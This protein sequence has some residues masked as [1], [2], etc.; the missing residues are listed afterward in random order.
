VKSGTV[1]RQ[2]ERKNWGGENIRSADF[3]LP[4]KELDHGSFDSIEN[5]WLIPS[6]LQYPIFNIQYSKALSR[7]DYR[8]V[9]VS[10]TE[11]F[12]GNPR[13][14]P[15]RRWLPSAEVMAASFGRF[16][17]APLRPQKEYQDHENRVVD[18]PVCCGCIRA[19][20]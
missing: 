18:L 3:S 4:K 17:Y 20:C 16:C 12:R 2:A 6:R 7:L 13:S 9:S 1:G 11:H 19:R 10:I 8:P 5:D 14:A 15:C